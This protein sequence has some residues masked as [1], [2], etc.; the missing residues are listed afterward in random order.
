MLSKEFIKKMKQR[1]ETE[2]KAVEEKIKKYQ[3][4][5]EPRDNPDVDEIAQDATEDILEEKLLAIHENILEKI[6]KAL[7]KIA[8]GRYGICEKCG[9]EIGKSDLEKEPWAEYCG[10]C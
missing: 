4:P 2:K 9:T 5:E 7:E 1:L 10:K 8:R 3:A 6:N